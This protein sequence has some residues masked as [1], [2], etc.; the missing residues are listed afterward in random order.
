MIY[1]KL[2]EKSGC[3]LYNHIE[4]KANKKIVKGERKKLILQY[5][6]IFKIQTFYKKV[7][8]VN[9]FFFTAIFF[10]NINS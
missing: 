4:Q 5:Q 6:N 10:R 9:Y 1:Q 8:V 7:I 3:T 2:N